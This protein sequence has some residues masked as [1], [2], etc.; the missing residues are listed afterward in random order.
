MKSEDINPF[1]EGTISTFS[2]MCNI[3]P[4]RN[5]K[6]FLKQGI[7]P[8]FDLIGFLGLSGTVRGAC[9]LS[10]PAETG[11]QVVTRFIGDEIS[12]INAD[13]LDG[14]GELINIIA[15]AAAGK[16]NGRITLALP[17]V[18]V[19]KDQLLHSKIGNPFVVV[20]MRF[21]EWG[22]FTIEVCME[23]V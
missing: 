21:E 9:I 7:S 8:T 12:E 16:L 13:L 14:Y 15:G 23:D 1:I 3:T 2:T 5:G 22:E 10:M 18:V 11:M 4:I 20:P 6:L 17:T 19:G